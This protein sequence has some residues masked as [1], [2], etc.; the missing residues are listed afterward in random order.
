FC[1]GGA[2]DPVKALGWFRSFLQTHPGAV[3]IL[4]IEDYIAPGDTRAAFAESG[5]L[6]YVYWHPPGEGWPTLGEL[7]GSGQR[8]IVMAEHHT[9]GI[10]WYLPAYYG[11]LEETPYRF[12][13]T[14]AVDAPDS[15]RENR[16]GNDRPFFLLNNWVESSVP[17]PDDPQKVNAFKPLLARAI[18]CERLRRHVPNLV[19]VDFYGKGDLFEVVNALNGLPRDARPQASG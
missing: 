17:S 9:G 15:C 2:T 4:D 1:E 5:L 10:P 7:I 12:T 19:A 13:S 11:Y 8:V 14:A 6:P 16:G 3:I 18:H